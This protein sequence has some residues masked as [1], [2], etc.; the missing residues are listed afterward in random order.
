MS[1]GTTELPYTAAR[2]KGIIKATGQITVKP[3]GL[4]GIQL[5]CNGATGDFTASITPANLTG[6]RR[7]ILPNRDDTFAGLGAQ[8]FT[9]AQT[10]SLGSLVSGGSAPSSATTGTTQWVS[11]T[12]TLTS[13]VSSTGAANEKIW[14]F[15]TSPTQ[16]SIE[17]ALDNYA[18]SNPAITIARSAA[19]PTVVTIAPTTASTSTTTGALVVTGG[20]GIGGRLNVGGDVAFDKTGAGLTLAIR[21]DDSKDAN[22]S[23]LNRSGVG[24]IQYR[25]VSSTDL[26]W[27]T[28]TAG[29]DILTL[30]NS[31]AST[32]SLFVNYS[33][34]STST[35][36]GA[37]VVTGGVG[38]GGRLNVGGALEVNSATLIKSNTT[39]TDGAAAAVGTLTNAPTA[40]NPTKWVLLNDNGVIR[41]FPT[42]T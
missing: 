30:S 39:L 37:L 29:I 27:Y 8:T 24:I 6:N 28:A 12:V 33:T 11:G 35:T 16:F 32:G 5:D 20:V 19:S 22:I 1:Y 7:W 18:S 40:G 26:R 38:I 23:F 17:A 10:F 9:G 2:I 3:A 34:A 25:P 15:R 36:T 4:A 14:D 41:K 31:S 42:W 21:A 13:F